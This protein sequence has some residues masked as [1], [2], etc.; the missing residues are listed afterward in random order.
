MKDKTIEGYREG[1]QTSGGEDSDG[2]VSSWE[3][4]FEIS[5]HSEVYEDQGLRRH[6]KC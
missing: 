2:T 4:S 5:N 3:T 6:G 1:M